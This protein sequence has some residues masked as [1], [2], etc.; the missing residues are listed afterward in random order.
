MKKRKEKFQMNKL[1]F[2]SLFQTLCVCMALDFVSYL[3]RPN[4]QTTDRSTDRTLM[5]SNGVSLLSYFF[6][7]LSLLILIF[8]EIKKNI[9]LNEANTKIIYN[10]LFSIYSIRYDL[11][12]ISSF[13]SIFLFV[14]LFV[15]IS[16]SI[17]M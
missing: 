13:F 1:I 16:I 9:S 7:L 3:E 10:N 14:R 17:S 12:I 11:S 2:F 8:N 15:S 5:T 6:F 4:K